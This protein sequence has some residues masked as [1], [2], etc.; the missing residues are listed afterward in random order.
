MATLL[1]IW[2]PASVFYSA[3]YTESIF[4]CTTFIAYYY[5]EE[6]PWAATIWFCLAS[7]TRSNGGHALPS[8]EYSGLSSALT[9]QY[10]CTYR[11][12]ELLVCAAQPAQSG[13]AKSQK[14]AGM[15]HPVSLL[16]FC[17]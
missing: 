9:S 2:N 5:V 8:A 3:T 10:L 17:T 11:S 15:L 6:Q 1:F 13:F 14:G 4:A 16:S 12:F 7:A